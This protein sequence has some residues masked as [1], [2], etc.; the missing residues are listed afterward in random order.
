MLNFRHSYRYKK[1]K[2]LLTSTYLCTFSIAATS[3]K[4]ARLK[5]ADTDGMSDGKLWFSATSLFSKDSLLH[6]I[7]VFNVLWRV[8]CSC[9]FGFSSKRK[10]NSKGCFNRIQS[11]LHW[12]E[13]IKPHSGF[14]LLYNQ[15]NMETYNI[16]TNSANQFSIH[17]LL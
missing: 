2:F 7:P 3:A 5:N 16:K 14:L 4:A 9:P 8:F 11:S 12:D 17:C 10:Q 15:T 1:A 13:K 6:S